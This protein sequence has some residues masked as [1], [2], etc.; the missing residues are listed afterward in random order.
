MD[1]E[2]NL[3]PIR[4]LEEQIRE[5]EKTAIRLKHVRNSLLN[6]SKP[7][8]EVLGKIFHWNVTLKGDFGG[9]DE[10]SHNFPPPVCHHWFEVASRTPELWSF[11]S[12]NL[13][14]WAR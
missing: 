2:V 12:N 13:K 1:C 7:P 14:D 10:G 3:N 6:V 8:P 9:L 11:W 4:A 5:H